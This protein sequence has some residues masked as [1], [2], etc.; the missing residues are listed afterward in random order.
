MPSGGQVIEQVFSR[1]ALGPHARAHFRATSVELFRLRP[2][3]RANIISR[4]QSRAAL[5]APY[6]E[7]V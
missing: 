4:P 7:Q 3:C 6:Q 1:K 2:P 5:S